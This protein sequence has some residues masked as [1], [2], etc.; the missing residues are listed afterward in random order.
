MAEQCANAASVAV[1]EQCANAA[2]VATVAEQCANAA[3]VAVAVQGMRGVHEVVTVPGTW[4]V[5]VSAGVV[6]EGGT[7]GSGSTAGGRSASVGGDTE[8]QG[9]ACSSNGAV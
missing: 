7:R 3:R 1:A 8:Y 5:Y 9:G 2:S 4:A 6:H